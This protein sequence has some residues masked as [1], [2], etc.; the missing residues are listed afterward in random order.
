MGTSALLCCSWEEEDA[1][2]TSSASMWCLVLPCFEASPITSHE[3]SPE[4]ACRLQ[5]KKKPENRCAV[6]RDLMGCADVKHGEEG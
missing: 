3:Q 4:A 6:W 1:E 2:A 5:K